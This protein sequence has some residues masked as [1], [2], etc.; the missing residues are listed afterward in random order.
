MD[1]TVRQLVLSRLQADTA[2]SEEAAIYI[3]SALEGPEELEIVLAPGSTGKPQREVLA[4]PAVQP[5]GAHLV[6][7]S[8][9]GFRGIGPPVRI[10]F[11]PGP[12]LT[13]I[14]GRNGSGKSSLAEGLECLLTGDSRRQPKPMLALPGW[15]PTHPA[16]IRCGSGGLTFIFHSFLRGGES[17]EAAT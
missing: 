6:S 1:A 4:A 3:I 12:G 15:Q 9:E 13:L 11:T 17:V 16:R 7:L 10:D 8:V 5:V 14:V 2:I